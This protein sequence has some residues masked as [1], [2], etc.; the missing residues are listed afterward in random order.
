[1]SAR[2]P[3]AVL[4]NPLKTNNE[5]AAFG[6]I[7]YQRSIPKDAQTLQIQRDGTVC[8]SIRRPEFIGQ[9]RK[10]Q[11]LMIK[12]NG[13]KTSEQYSHPGHRLPKESIYT[14]EQWFIKNKKKPYLNRSTLNAL[15]M[16]TR[17]SP[18]QVKNWIS[19]RRRRERV[20]K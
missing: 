15:I 7:K 5:K 19:N 16:E 11:L 8:E 13:F 6:D 2:I 20:W 9:T 3:I 1:M 18:S 12:E 14:L 17:L 4:L 10:C